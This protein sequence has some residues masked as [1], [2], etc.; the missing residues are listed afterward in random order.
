MWV[1]FSHGDWKTGGWDEWC[2]M[3]CGLSD[4]GMCQKINAHRKNSTSGICLL[5]SATSLSPWGIPAGLGFRSGSS[6]CWGDGSDSQSL[7]LSFILS[8]LSQGGP[9]TKGPRGERGDS[10]PTVSNAFVSLSSHWTH[11][12]I[13][14]DSLNIMD[15]WS[16]PESDF[17]SSHILLSWDTVQGLT[18]L[19]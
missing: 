18:H 2:A 12:W 14:S 5:H 4:L 1:F 7:T 15:V 9:G 13:Q 6:S 3:R 11:T 16:K 8:W 17:K 10:G 19:Q